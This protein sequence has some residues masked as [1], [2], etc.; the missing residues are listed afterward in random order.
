MGVTFFVVF[1]LQ[2]ARGY[3]PLA[4]GVSMLPFALAQLVASARSAD[5]VKRWGAKVVCTFGLTVMAATFVGY[6]AVGTHSSIWVL[7]TL[8]LLQGLAIGT[9]MPPATESIMSSV[10]REKAGA[11]SAINNVARQVGGAIGIA[12]IGT[13]LASSY[14]DKLAPALQA[15][16]VPDKLRAAME[17]SV[18]ATHSIVGQAHL[19]SAVLGDA[20]T[21]FVHAMHIAALCSAAV[22]VLGAVVAFAFLPGRRGEAT[23]NTQPVEPAKE[24]AG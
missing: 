20:N 12:V 9:I 11:G 10:P 23:M 14:R 16:G 18:E 21:A 17:K 7:E 5:W 1:Y 13:V 15:T 19:P 8:F 4:A 2:T 24:M 6:L 22:G 3:S